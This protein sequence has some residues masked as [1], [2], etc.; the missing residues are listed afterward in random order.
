MK[1][2]LI[3]IIRNNPFI[4]NVTV[5]A[6]GTAA[7]Q[8]ITLISSPIITRLYGPEAFGIMGVF[9]AI[10]Q[11]FAPISALTYPIAIVLPK[12]DRN[13]KSIIRLSL[14]LCL[15]IAIL[16]L[17]ILLFFNE[18]IVTLFQIQEVSSYLYLIPLVVIFSGI[19]QV[20]EQ[21]LIRTKQFGIS[22]KAAVFQSTVING[23]KVGIGFFN[24]VA[25]VLIVLSALANGLKASIMI[26]FIKKSNYKEQFSQQEPLLSMTGLAKK[27]KDFPL[28]RAP[29]VLINSL[30]QRIPV[31]MLTTFFG[32]VAAG[33]Y[34]LGNT[35]LQKPIQ[36]IGN[37]V[38]DV[39]YPRISEA[40]NNKESLTNLIKKAT[41]ALVGIGIVPFG[42]VIIFGPWLFSFVFGEEWFTAGKYA[43]WLGIFLFC[44]FINKPSVK[45]LPVLSAQL[46][47]LNFTIITA[48]VRIAAL[49]VG[50]FVF[51]SD[52]VAIA[53]FGISSAVLHIV[54][55]LLVLR[56][57]KAFDIDNGTI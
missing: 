19:M 27:Y 18:S 14:Y 16:I 12:D 9:T 49:L 53:L 45:A 51:S 44:E 55:I 42:L 34:T 11:M 22:A 15:G 13:A 36:L 21:W 24:P 54:L 35:V 31:L 8:L 29:E 39:F 57:S 52:L 26:F 23:S 46:F 6:T 7:A 33:F 50:Y 47:H 10:I 32:P 3:K 56:K 41:L 43:Q 20:S 1:E 30:S 5:L 17:L 4:R 25:S 38:G 28:F 2:K 40:A 48:I 37:S